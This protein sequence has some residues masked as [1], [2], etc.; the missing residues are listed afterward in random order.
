MLD[1]TSHILSMARKAQQQP[2]DLHLL[3]T[4]TNLIRV[5][6]IDDGRFDFARKSSLWNL[7]SLGCADTVATL[8]ENAAT[9][10]PS[11]RWGHHN[12]LIKFTLFEC[13]TPSG[14]TVSIWHNPRIAE[15]L[16]EY[17]VIGMDEDDV[18]HM[19]QFSLKDS[20]ESVVNSGRIDPA[21]WRADFPYWDKGCTLLHLAVKFWHKG[22]DLMLDLVLSYVEDHGLDPNVRNMWGHTALHTAVDSGKGDEL[23]RKLLIDCQGLDVSVRTED[24]HNLKETA[25]EMALRLS[26]RSGDNVKRIVHFKKIAKMLQQE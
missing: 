10:P 9:S 21:K 19:F 20:L 17:G 13:Y 12:S 15:L 14:R 1:D 3:N 5:L 2:I 8:L 4:L 16:L 22:F 24:Y 25:A 6:D 11:R 26:Q 18:E 7:V 23:V